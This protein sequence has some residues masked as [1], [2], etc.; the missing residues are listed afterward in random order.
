MDFLFGYTYKLLDII[1]YDDEKK[2]FDE[3]SHRKLFDFK[4][5]T[6]MTKNMT[7]FSTV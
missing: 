1:F 5:K 3:I 4:T 2:T 7:L 6:E